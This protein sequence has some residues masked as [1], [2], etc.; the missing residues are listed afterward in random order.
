MTRDQFNALFS[1][2][3]QPCIIAGD[4]NAK[5]P[6]WGSARHN[7][8]GI[9]LAAA[10]E[11]SDLVMLNDCSI[12]RFDASRS[13]S[14]ID[15]TLVSSG[16]SLLFNWKVIEEPNGSDHLPISCGTFTPLVETAVPAINYR[17]MDWE[18][19][20]LNM[21]GAISCSD[22]ELTYNQFFDML[23]DALFN[24]SPQYRHVGVHKVPQ[25]FWDEELSEALQESR[26]KFKV[27]P[28]T[29][30]YENYYEY[31]AHD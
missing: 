21:E 13:P 14:A 20:T 19:F 18:K 8:R 29:L 1:S 9:S 30:E 16:I 10:L 12:T 11:D 7:Q 17:R 15:L 2:V 23:L 25:P 31:L 26:L 5:H 27:W 28:R 4:W 22:G 6:M 24:A 3:P